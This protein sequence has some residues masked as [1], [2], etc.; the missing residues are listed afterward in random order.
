MTTERKGFDLKAFY[1][2]LAA[3]ADARDLTWKEV[4]KTTGVSQSTLSRMATGRH[5]DA[6]SL[7]ALAHWA[8]LDPT[9]FY[10]GQRGRTETL[11]SVTR[12]LRQD[13]A[14]DHEAAEA[15]ASIFKAAYERFKA[16]DK[17]KKS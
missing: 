6:A 2:A 1:K 11:A 3:T 10:H 9:G 13:P 15:M 7:T 5:P 4:S 17:T 8:G 12:L 16:P 14:L